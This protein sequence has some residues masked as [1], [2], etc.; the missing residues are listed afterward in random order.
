MQGPERPAAA[1]VYL[2]F[3][4]WP[5]N[6]TAFLIV[7]GPQS[8]RPLVASFRAAVRQVDGSIPLYNIR[9]FEDVRGEY[10]EARRFAMT[11][12]LT[13]GVVASALAALGLFGVL[14]YT[15]RLRGKEL[16]IRIALGATAQAVRREVIYSGIL[17]AFT[18][19]AVG[20]GLAF[21]SWRAAAARVPGL[22][23][24]DP[25]D[26]LIVAASVLALT[27]LTTWLPAQ[28]A[29]RTDPLGVLRAD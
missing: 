11:L 15:I 22:E 4:Q 21:V 19:L 24:L 5:I 7:R 17:R 26:V 3:A 2:P 14:T 8:A 18:G 23:R 27:V 13:F 25:V 29:A 28:R 1:A 20:V 9:T 6:S 16:G 12:M 10:L